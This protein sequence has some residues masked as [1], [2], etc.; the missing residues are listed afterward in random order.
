VSWVHSQGGSERAALWLISLLVLGR[1]AMAALT[2]LTPDEAYYALWARSL[3][4]GYYDHPPMIAFFIRAGTS[5]L[6][7]TPLGVRLFCA[8]SAI[9]ASVFVWRAAAILAAERRAAPLAALFFNLT[10]LGY[11][12][13]VVATPDAPL[14][15]FAAAML[16][17]AARL[18]TS[19][20]LAHWLAMGV[21]T[22]LAFEAKYSAALLAAGF[23]VA[24]LIIPP[25]RRQLL[26]P[27]PWLALFVSVLV[28]APNIAWNATHG[29]ATF[30]K[31]GGRVTEEQPFAPRYLLELVGAQL[32]L[33]T[34]F[35]LALAVI[36]LLPAA[37][38]A[39]RSPAARRLLLA[40][41]LV[42]T[43]Y[44]LFHALRARVEGNWP[45]FLYP[46]LAIAAAVAMSREAGGVRG[47]LS[48][49]AAP[50]ALAIVIF[51]SIYVVVGPLPALGRKDPI[52]RMTRGWNELAAEIRVL[53]RE[54]GAGYVVTHDY[55]LNAELVLLL[56]ELKV[57][58]ANDRERYATLA[59]P[60][61]EAFRGT[62]LMVMR[63]ELPGDFKVPFATITS[64]GTVDQRYGDAIITPFHIY[65]V[66]IPPDF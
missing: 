25:W 62:G 27:K 9:P 54:N 61:P 8:L 46:A 44:F 14:V 6:G 38:A 40:L 65:R 53:A 18:T 1:L 59:E 23:S 52:L 16:Y 64:L 42:P 29:W 43:A 39:Y 22:G 12:G 47:F 37:A 3:S 63:T 2:P 56:P 36:G 10:L 24:V 20:H 30:L 31:Q 15:L 13:L 26:G 45:G 48:R 58:Q 35:I 57:A 33:A 28:F 7:E 5:L 55:Q 4:A 51:G 50:V 41:L 19:D 17:C 11:F 60:R 34:P 32:G 66:D 49:F 21:A